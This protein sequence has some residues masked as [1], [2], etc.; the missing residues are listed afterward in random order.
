MS[1]NAYV[2][3]L[4]CTARAKIQQPGSTLQ[5]SLKWKYNGSW[6]QGKPE[7]LTSLRNKRN[8]HGTLA[9]WIT[10]HQD[11]TQFNI[12][13]RAQKLNKEANFCRVLRWQFLPVIFWPPKMLAGE[14]DAREAFLF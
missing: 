7:H 6:V 1:T 3:A 2:K 8:K 9:F 13:G 10:R 14:T 5:V 12:C 11:H 4:S